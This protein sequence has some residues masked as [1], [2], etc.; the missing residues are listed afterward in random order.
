MA[1]QR[2]N[3]QGGANRQGQGGAGPPRGRRGD[4]PPAERKPLA[5]D[6]PVGGDGDA[7]GDEGTVRII[8]FDIVYEPVDEHPRMPPPVK[9]QFQELFELVMDLPA[10]AIDRLEP[11]VGQWPDVP[12]L[13][14]LLMVANSR[15]G[16]R[17]EAE[18][19]TEDS[20]VRFPD[21]LFARINFA[22]L[23]LDRG[24]VDAVVAAIG[25]D[26]DL[27]RIYPGRKR[28]HYSEVV[29]LYTLM[30]DYCLATGARDRAEAC[31]DLLDEIAPDH[32][33]TKAL[34]NRLMLAVFEEAARRLAAR[35]RRQRAGKKTPR[36]K[37]GGGHH[38]GTA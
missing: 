28:F 22:Q 25:G 19:L 16:R 26:F 8:E 29:G 6:R 1:G 21:Y 13:A 32:P 23:V 36:K 27:T 9:A 34:E 30:G 2:K 18:R 12:Q 37:K 15:A 33:A 38:R 17:E 7:E 10:E 20:F 24:H 5:A 14:N 3:P 4:R 35:P 31:L 11:L